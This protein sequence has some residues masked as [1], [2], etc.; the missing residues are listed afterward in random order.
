MKSIKMGISTKLAALMFGAALF[1]LVSQSAL[2]AGTASGTSITNAASLS[3]TVGGVGQAAIPASAAFV[4]DN[5]VN[6]TVARVDGAP[7]S[8]VPGSVAVNAVTTFTVTNNG[9]TSQDFAL[10]AVDMANGTAN[11]FGGPLTDSFVAGA[12]TITNIVLASGSIGPYTAGDQHINALTADSSATVSVTCSIPAN[13]ANNTL[14]V[15]SL[16]ATAH[17]DD[18]ANTLGAA[19][20]NSNGVADIPGTVQIVFAD[21]V[22]GPA[23]GDTALNGANSTLDAYLV[24]TAA[25]TVTKTATPICDPADGNVNPKN[26]PGAAVRYVVTIANTG[27]AAATLT[28]LSDTL[29][30]QLAF[31]TTLNSGALPATNCVNGNGANSLSASGFGAVRGVG[32]GPGVIGVAADATTAGASVAGQVITINYLTLTSTSYGAANQTLNAGDF[33]TVYYNAFV[34]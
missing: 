13:Q 16:T 6:M 25:L 4:V 17:A 28:S 15:I 5:K 7:V 32:A 27:S 11:P 12:C 22:A 33:I 2:A 34:Q 10:A 24:Q 29:P 30:A 19:L 21:T 14:A 9:N 3:Y 18:A 8:V 26:I 20:V 23:V 31:D 1:G